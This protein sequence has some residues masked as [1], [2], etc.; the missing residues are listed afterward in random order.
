MSVG[1]KRVYGARRRPRIASEGSGKGSA[2]EREFE[3]QLR[4][5]GI[6]GYEREYRFAAPRRWRFDFA[7]P[8][9]KLA[10]EI[11]GGIWSSGRHTRGKGFEADCV[12]YANALVLGWRVLRVTPTHVRDGQALRW[13]ERLARQLLVRA[14]YR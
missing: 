14:C 4:A 6:I 2:P 5:T 10:V 1:R 12:K 9:M 3:V 8:S 11:E 13:V 7:W